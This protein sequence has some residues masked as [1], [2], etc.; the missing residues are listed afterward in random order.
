MENP[1]PERSKANL[2]WELR[3][4]NPNI[5]EEIF[6]MKDLTLEDIV[7]DDAEIEGVSTRQVVLEQ[8]TPEEYERFKKY[9]E[10]K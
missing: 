3:Q 1:Y 7:E 10:E 5:I 6:V 9:L 8:Q 2:F 4:E